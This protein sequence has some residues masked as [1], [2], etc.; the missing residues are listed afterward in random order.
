[1]YLRIKELAEDSRLLPGVRI[2]VEHLEKTV[3]GGNEMVNILFRVP[4]KVTEVTDAKTGRV[5]VSS[6]GPRFT[7]TFT[8]SRSLRANLR[9]FHEFY[10]RRSK[11]GE[12]ER[13]KKVEVGGGGDAAKAAAARAPGRA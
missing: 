1:L 8:G 2:E 4:R 11:A 13:T 9:D 5:E 10:S 7:Y 12:P 3:R 6:S